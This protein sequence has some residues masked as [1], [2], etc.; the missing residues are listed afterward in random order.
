MRFL[1]C[2]S[3]IFCAAVGNLHAQDDENVAIDYDVTKIIGLTAEISAFPVLN[4]GESWV[5]IYRDGELF[6][7]I[8]SSDAEYTFLTVGNPKGGWWTIKDALLDADG[9]TPMED[10]MGAQ[11]E[12][13]HVGAEVRNY[14]GQLVALR[15]G[16]SA[17]AAVV[18][19]IG[20]KNSDDAYT[21]PVVRLIDVS[22]D[23]EWVKVEVPSGIVD[24]R[25]PNHGGIGWIQSE[26]LCGNPLTNCN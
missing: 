6:T 18:F 8:E 17:S 11:I 15:E 26:W 5:G 22:A 9:I 4:E 16:P 23:G 12:Y 20:K 7:K 24:V 10:V 13:K 19:S 1:L 25:K 21:A 2:L 14:E 3:V